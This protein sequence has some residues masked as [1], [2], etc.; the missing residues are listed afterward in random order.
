VPAFHLPSFKVPGLLFGRR[1]LALATVGLG[2]VA[3]C[4]GKPTPID[5]LPDARPPD[6][7]AR[8]EIDGGV[9]TTCPVSGTRSN[10][11][12]VVNDAF[13]LQRFSFA[14]VMDQIRTTADVSTQS[15]RGIFEAWMRTF[16]ASAASGD[17]DDAMID[18]NHYGLTCP[19]SP[20]FKLASVDPFSADGAVQFAPLGLFNR[21]D[22]APADGSNC[23]EY[24][25]VFGMTSRTPAITGRALIIFEGI[26]ANPTPAA[27]INACLPV[28]QF[29]QGLSS[30]R[31]P[32]TRA[33]QLERFYFT[34]D[35][36]PGFPPVVA[37]QSYGLARG[38]NAL[39]GMGQ[40][41]TNFFI[42]AVEWQLR[43]FKLR[44]ACSSTDAGSC[45]LTF[46]HLPVKSNPAEELFTGNHPRSDSFTSQFV[47]QVPRLVGVAPTELNLAPADLFNEFESVSSRGDVA[48][49]EFAFPVVSN[50]IA[51]KLASM[52]SSLTVTDVLNRATTQTC[53]GCHQRSNN[54]DLG[55]GMRWPA[56][57]EFVHIDENSRLSPAL[58][59]TFLP[60]RRDVLESFINLRCGP[61]PTARSTGLAD[62]A[63]RAA[64][65]HHLTV[66]GSAVGAAN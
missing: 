6:P 55:R 59:T 51:D 17:C 14:R 43:E 8:P 5:P 61:D 35:A 48:Y 38:T 58:T 54:V 53:A 1:S 10:P 23:G 11:S 16:G 65:A 41:R 56:S 26:L 49:A 63:M 15:S 64:A 20:E 13:T 66:G 37:A 50:R 42:D 22:L 29:W 57:L 25:I 3:G 21:F 28:A 39:H 34:G 44:R 46:E 4:P 40:V 52:G 47:A 60:H 7:D 27:G 24:R 31:S 18:P 2:L 12:L 45:R 62:D 33:E 19:R 32:I 36:V 30:E 9:V